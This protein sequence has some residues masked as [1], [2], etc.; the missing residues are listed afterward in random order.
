[1]AV[2]GQG[3]EGR[4]G[5][6]CL[7]VAAIQCRTQG[8][9][10]QIGEGPFVPGRFDALSRCPGQT[11]HVAQ[12]NSHRRLG[13]CVLVYGRRRRLQ[14][15]FPI[16]Y[17]HIHRP[18]FQAVAPPVLDEL[19]R[20]VETHRPAVE[21]RA[22]KRRRLMTF[23]PG[24]GIGEQGEA[25]SMGFGKAVFAEAFDLPP[26]LVSECR[27]IATPLHAVEQPLAKTCEMI[28]LAPGTDGAPQ[29]IGLTGGKTCRHHRQLDHLFLKNGHTQ[30][31]LQHRLH[32]LAGI[33]NRLTAF[34][35]G[36]KR[37][38]HV[39]LDGAGADNGH[40]H[41]QIVET[42]RFQPW[43]HGHLR[44]GFDLEHAHGVGLADHGVSGWI[45]GRHIGQCHVFA[46]PVGHQRQ[47]TAD[48]REHAE[49]EHIHLEQTQRIEIILVP[50]D[51]RAFGH[52]GIFDGHQFR[53]CAIGNDETAHM[54]RQMARHA[55]EF[56]H[57]FQKQR[58]LRAVRIKAF[59]A[60]ALALHLTTVPP[61]VVLRDALHLFQIEPQRLAR[62]ADGAARAVGD[63]RGGQRRT[64]AAVFSVDV[65]DDFL[66][67]LVFKVHI[68]V[69][70]FVT[71]L[72]DETFEQ[73]FHARRIHLRDAEA[74]A[75]RRV[76][77]RTA[78]L[79]Q[80]AARAREG[81][82]VVHTEKKG[83]VLQFGNE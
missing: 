15:T 83:L 23:E 65:L 56:V 42:P 67:P 38:H 64:F 68:D 75:H 72:G 49:R 55:D 24:R 25:G 26:D 80:N 53:K 50:L 47:A 40:F 10:T 13:A 1:M 31:A 46:T 30:G 43:Q 11:L 58:Q 2:T 66:A 59:L 36:E 77:R 78:P 7:H 16:A 32:F 9:I 48:G 41:H 34:A 39:A 70:R 20:R 52:G 54:L 4:G 51:H 71:F 44:A 33:G 79:A 5:S 17:G 76:R 63:D 45:L 69:G 14:R 57:P 62:I 18:H 3:R 37:M 27:R 21:Q 60:Q 19:R 12:A 35:A 82:D 73:H 22:Q 6:Q 28:A 74:V 81:H 8:E 29:L 61:G